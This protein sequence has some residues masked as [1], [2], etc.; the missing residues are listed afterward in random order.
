[1]QTYST[2]AIRNVALAGHNGSGKTSLAEAML[3]LRKHID[4]MGKTED[5]ATQSDYLPEETARGISISAALLPVETPNVKINVVDLPGFR[6]FVGDIQ[7]G[8]SVCEAL[9]VVIDALAGMEVGTEFVLDLAEQ[10]R[11]PVAFFLN[12]LNKEHAS[13]DKALEKLTAGLPGHHLLPVNLPIG[14]QMKFEGVVDL[15]RMQAIYPKEGKGATGPIPENLAARSKELHSAVVDEAASD[16]E[17]LTERYLAGEQLSPEEIL[18]GLKEGFINRKYHPVF[19]G[20]TPQTIGVQ[21]VLDFIE[22]C[23]PNPTEA[24]GINVTNKQTG[25]HTESHGTDKDSPVLYVYKTLTDKFG[26]NS[27]VKVVSGC[28]KKDTPLYNQRDGKEERITHIYSQRG[29]NS[30][31]VTELHAGDLGVLHKLSHTHTNDTLAA[32]NSPIVVEPPPYP[33]ATVRM[34]ISAKNQ[35]DDDKLGT[36]LHRYALQDPTFSYHRDPELHQ[37]ILMGQGD[38]HLDVVLQRVKGEKVDAAMTMPRTAYRETV[39]RKSEGMY[40]HK[41]QSGGRGQFAEVH[42]RV[43]PAERGKGLDF[44]W[45]IVGGVVPTK[46]EPSVRKGVDSALAKGPLAGYPV[47]D[48]T[49]ECF[50]GKQHD[51][52]S[53]DMAFQLASSHAFL[54]VASKATPILLEPIFK[55]R[56]TVP[57]HYLG[58][59]MGDLSGRRGRIL[60]QESEGGRIV[61]E[62]LVPLAETYEYSRVLRAM[63]HGRGAFEMEYDHYD[64][65]PPDVQTKLVEAAHA[66]GHQVGMSTH[67]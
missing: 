61:L 51:V 46:Y 11:L 3:F 13:F 43:G 8:L 67:G 52:D 27:F 28:L 10:S 12:K 49:V 54:E 1:V 45:K 24:R 64:R 5:G 38:L 16:D 44:Q 2:T 31:E 25:E 63:T 7:N 6:D 23:F 19:C 56:I 60:G 21:S 15:V 57:E 47:V 32:P 29:K 37:T 36:L 53:S 41:K 40:R 30:M 55:L 14:E 33:K 65:V 18:H 17:S 42:L 20:A 39:V 35:G 50:D 48:V 26:A 34:A 22:I 9:V 58:D 66:A 59:V 4:R 62:A